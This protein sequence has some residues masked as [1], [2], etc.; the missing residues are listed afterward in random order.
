[1]SAASPL[2]AYDEIVAFFAGGPSREAIATFQL[3]EETKARV[4]YL[5]Q[6]NSAGTL[7]DEESE[8]LDHCVH[9]DRLM[10]LIRSQARQQR[11]S[12]VGA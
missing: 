3:S 12:T 5:L 6:K 9:L 2:H 11:Q 1:M 10:L 7:T 4:R 8:E